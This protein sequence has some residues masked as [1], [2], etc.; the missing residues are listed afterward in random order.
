MSKVQKIGSAL[1]LGGLGAY[2][3]KLFLANDL[4]LYIH[5]RYEPYT[6]VAGIVVVAAMC[7][8]VWFTVREK[9]VR[10]FHKQWWRPSVLTLL[11]LAVLGS[12]WL[13]EP[14]PLMSSAA[15][16][17]EV[18]SSTAA[19]APKTIQSTGGPITSYCPDLGPIR[20]M[21]LQRWSM[22]L[23][24][25]LEPDAYQNERVAIEGFIYRPEGAPLPDG[26]VFAARFVINCC[27]IDASPV[28][29]RVQTNRQLPAD[30]WVRI[31]GSVGSMEFEGQERL[32]IIAEDVTVIDEPEEPYAYW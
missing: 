1:L 27:A 4:D 23:E 19:L 5:P 12:M 25:C 17:K 20:P 24:G 26:M 8:S 31:T 29:L 30:T 3:V 14:R 6:L 28:T 18:S 10:V 21:N 15:A 2:A 7:A 11:L 16:Q 9:H 22:V 13:T 32:G